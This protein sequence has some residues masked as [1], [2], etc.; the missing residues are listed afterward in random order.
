MRVADFTI[1]ATPATASV[2]AGQTSG[3]VALAYSIDYNIAA[4]G[5]NPNVTF[6]CSGLPTGATCNF[7]NTTVTPTPGA[8][9]IVSASA[10]DSLTIS[11]SGP[12]LTKAS[13]ER[14]ETPS[15]RGL[16]IAVA[17]VLMLGLPL[18]F[19]RKRLLPAGFGLVAL[20][21]A[22][23]LSGCGGNSTPTTPSGYTPSGGTPA[24]TSTVT[25]TATVTGGNGVGTLSHTATVALTVTSAAN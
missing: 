24:G 1:T 21:F 25:V 9:S 14:P 2:V 23:C 12:T 3:A 18:A 22:C 11:T 10:S 15:H 16:G 17:G 7:T 13:L 8:S 4:F 6:A 20:L 19:R 5:G